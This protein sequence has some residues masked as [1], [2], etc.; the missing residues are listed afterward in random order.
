MLVAAGTFAVLPPAARPG[1]HHVPERLHLQRDDGAAGNRADRQHRL[2]RRGRPAVHLARRGL[3][4]HSG[5]GAHAG[6]GQRVA[7]RLSPRTAPAI[8]PTRSATAWSTV[9]FAA[10]ADQ[11]QRD[12]HR[13]AQSGPAQARPVHQGHG[14]HAGQ[15]RTGRHPLFIEPNGTVQAYSSPGSHAEQF[16]SLAGISYPLGS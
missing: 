8:R 10:A 5:G 2:L 9:R 7:S 14:L 4:P 13:A 16:T 1:A 12:L 15:R 3:V 6:S 11:R